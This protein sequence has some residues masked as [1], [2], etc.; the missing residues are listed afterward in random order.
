MAYTE[1][2]CRSGGSNLNAGTRTG[3]STEPGTGASLTY[4]SG[5]WVSATGVF[6][7][8]SGDPVAD[9]VAVGDFASVYANG[10]SVTTLVGRV[11]ARTSTTITVSTTVKTGTTTDGTSN[12]T[13]RIGG[14][15]LGPNGSSG[16]PMNFLT[17]ACQNTAG[18]LPRINYKNDA[19]F[20]ITANISGVGAN[21]THQGYTTAYG[22]FGK[23]VLNGGTSGT[24]YTLI[25]STVGT[26]AS[27]ADFWLKNNGATGTAVGL[28]WNTSGV[29]LRVSVSNILGT[30]VQ[31]N[32]T[33][34]WESL[35]VFSCSTGGMVLLGPGNNFL[36]CIWHDNTTYGIRILSYAVFANC[37]AES[38]TTIGFQVESAGD[39]FLNCDAYNNTSD[40]LRITV[41]GNT[42]IRII[43]SNFVKN[44]GWG[45]NGVSG[46]YYGR[47]HNCGFGSGSQANTSG[48][49]TGMQSVD[50]IGT[51]TYAADVTPWVD[52]AN[53]D[54]RINLAAAQN[55]GL[56]FFQQCAA[57]YSGTV[58]Y[59]DIGAAQS[60]ASGGSTLIVIED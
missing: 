43:N 35:E 30:G 57:G 47:I 2:C 31:T 56:Q 41:G 48:T 4:A 13:L 23:A 15:W 21:T 17:S 52:P 51:V 22:D 53:G 40:G 5:T 45:I 19:E 36:N 37:I 24:A 54:F 44:G 1:F 8:A 7:V 28:F 10:A 18:D 49:V 59:P 34:F 55:A 14:A 27:L 33:T 12:R 6:T 20:A 25:G 58:G 50:V 16:F 46:K 42:D 39:L 11:T 29:V 9:G 38:N 32:A 3:N 60:A 26:A